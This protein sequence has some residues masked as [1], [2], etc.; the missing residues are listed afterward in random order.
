VASNIK[1]GVEIFGVTGSLA[2]VGSSPA[3]SNYTAQNL[4][5]TTTN[6][7]YGTTLLREEYIGDGDFAREWGGSGILGTVTF[8]TIPYYISFAPLVVYLYGQSVG[9]PAQEMSVGC[10]SD[11]TFFYTASGQYV[12]NL[13]KGPIPIAT[14][15]KVRLMFND[16]YNSAGYFTRYYTISIWAYLSTDYKTLYI[17]GDLSGCMNTNYYMYSKA[18]SYITAYY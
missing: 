11:A 13:G 16:V 4:T 7:I 18:S 5:M 17:F 6:T 2:A 10:G 8:T 12:N 9:R 1:S 14:S 3:P 15:N